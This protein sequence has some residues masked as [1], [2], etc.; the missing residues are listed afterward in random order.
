[1]K[2]ILL[3]LLLLFLFLVQVK[4]QE[5]Y[6]TAQSGYKLGISKQNLNL[7][8][9]LGE[10]EIE[11]FNNRINENSGTYTYQEVPI[12]LGQ[13]LN[14]ALNAGINLK[15]IGFEI[16]GNYSISDKFV[17]SIERNGIIETSELSSKQFQIIPSLVLK[18]DTGKLVVYSKLGLIVAIS[19]ITHSRY[20]DEPYVFTTKLSGG[21]ALG[22]NSTIGIEYKLTQNIKFISELN[23]VNLSYAP[24]KAEII[25]LNDEGTNLLPN[26]PDE[27][28]MINLTDKY[29]KDVGTLG[30]TELKQYFPYNSI[31]LNI[32]IR[33]NF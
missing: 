27:N 32:G 31:S 22:V 3:A 13:G 8:E 9:S 12:S 7:E 24:K 33:I 17:A 18:Y 23:L 15:K 11:N 29:I 16:T 25:E 5:I 14:I 28:K 1:M 30:N 10:F 26:I 6:I 4:S 21:Y 2:K 20:T 19:E